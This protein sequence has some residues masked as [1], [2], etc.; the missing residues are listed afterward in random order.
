VDPE[1]M[2]EFKEN[3]NSIFEDDQ[4]LYPGSPI[5]V[6]ESVVMNISCALRHNMTGQCL[7]DMLM[8]CEM[9][10]PRPNNCKTSL[11]KVKQQFSTMTN[12]IIHHVFCASCGLLIPK[13]LPEY[14]LNALCGKSMKESKNTSYFIEIPIASQIEAFF[15]RE[16]FHPDI[17][18]RFSRVKEGEYNIEDVYDG[19]LYKEQSKGLLSKPTNLSLTWYTD[20]APPFKSSKGSL[21]PV[22]FVINELPPEKRM[23]FE[24]MIIAGL[25]F[26]EGKPHMN[27][28][29]K[30]IC[31]SLEDLYSNGIDVSC[32][33]CNEGFN[34]KVVLLCGTCDLPA[35][36]SVL[37]MTQ[38]NGEFGCSNCMQPG[39]VVTAGRGHT[40]VFPINENDVAGPCRSQEEMIMHS[41]Q[42]L[43]SGKPVKGVKGPSW[44]STLKCHDIVRGTGI[45]YMHGV[46]LGVVRRLLHLW[47]DSSFSKQPF[48]ISKRVGDIDKRLLN[49]KPP[50]CISRLPRSISVHVKQWK[51][52][53]LRSWLFYYS[54]PV[55][56]GILS[57]P[58]YQLHL[59]LVE[60][61]YTL[62]QRSISPDEIYHCQRVL[63]NYC[64]H[65]Q[66]MYGKR[67][68]TMNV[69][70][71]LHLTD[72]VKRLG[73]LW[74]F[75]C[76]SFE[77]MNGKLLKFIHGGTKPI[78]Q[79]AN[80]VA[81]MFKITEIGEK[82]CKKK[83][84]PV[85]DFLRILRNKGKRLALTERIDEGSY[86]IGTIKQ[87]SLEEYQVPLQLALHI[88]AT[89]VKSFLRAKVGGLIVCSELYTALIGRISSVV[90]M[91]PDDS[92][93]RVEK[94]LR[95]K[96]C[97][98]VG[99]CQCEP[100][101]LV[102]IRKY[103]AVDFQLCHDDITDATLKNIRVVSLPPAERSFTFLSN[104]SDS[105]VYM[106]IQGLDD[107]AF[108]VKPPN[109]LE[110]D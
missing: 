29:L 63:I 74:V 27:S 87:E 36:C 47:F 69:H 41:G 80:S 20:G 75:S 6:A 44:F 50:D 55:L 8:I 70:Q 38:F 108:V 61:I 13:P 21:W 12:E 107:K 91:K 51:A 1:V 93:G 52:N 30:P 104:I 95:V 100:T 62:N 65:F 79:I 81:I 71:L 82:L 33:H 96:Q 39:E 5:T 103:S 45:D 68:M 89:E 14:C 53:E 106:E 102:E 83:D 78:K 19:E 32:G 54:V 73:P 28:Y 40:R 35:K 16:Y 31:D 60:A 97:F 72:V 59:L 58:F 17:M 77:G 37:N 3:K 34:T 23:R 94:L 64:A 98:C 85:G 90:C 25:W 4:P 109:H 99:K 18:H 46:L 49:I 10:C 67:H 105:C 76:F 101:Y 42:A 26:G 24:N 9:H 48:S 56:H 66:D 110:G 86:V 22:C 7:A 57:E 88:K 43:V 84:S 11:Y 15:Q 92:V 2:T